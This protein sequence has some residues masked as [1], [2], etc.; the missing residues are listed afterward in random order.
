MSVLMLENTGQNSAVTLPDPHH[1][2]CAG[3]DM[4][5]TD[6]PSSEELRQL[7]RYEPGTGNLSWLPRPESMF[8]AARNKTA[9]AVC[10]TWN[11]RFSGK[12]ALAQ[13]NSAG[14]RGGVILGHNVMAH[15][16]I[17][18]MVTGAWPDLQIDHIN[19]DRTDNRWFNLRH[20]DNRT[21]SKNQKRR[22]TNTS[23]HNGVF[24]MK[25][26]KKWSAKVGALY[27]GVFASKEAAIAAQRDAA[28][29]AGYTAS[30]GGR[31]G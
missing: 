24:W 23:G 5:K 3:V 26:A 28:A 7:L 10:L 22:A 11:K 31:E 29:R 12:P 8:R 19:G 16:L 18:A 17:W 25:S 20:V 4:A 6:L 27:L 13:I 14:Y 15:R 9:E 21:N 2:D 30:H 1:K